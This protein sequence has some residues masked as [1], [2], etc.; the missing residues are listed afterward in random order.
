MIILVL[1]ISGDIQ[2]NPGPV[3]TRT[4]ARRLVLAAKEA[5]RG[6]I[7][8]ADGDF[9]PVTPKQTDTREAETRGREPRFAAT[10]MNNSTTN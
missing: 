3:L 2:L 10:M 9:P 5:P 4:Q 6:Y 8:S 7:R 1:L